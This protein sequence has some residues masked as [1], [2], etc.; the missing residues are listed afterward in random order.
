MVLT[1]VLI[2]TYTENPTH[3][4]E[5][6]VSPSGA[7]GIYRASFDTETGALSDYALAAEARISPSW[8]RAHPNLPVV[9]SVNETCDGEG[10]DCTPSFVSAYR[11]GPSGTLSLLSRVG[12]GGGSACNFALSPAGTHLAVANH[13]LL[14]GDDSGVS[15]CEILLTWPR[16]Q[17]RTGLKS[18]NFN[19]NSQYSGMILM[20]LLVGA[21]WHRNPISY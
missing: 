20:R 13:G 8:L 9:Y 5:F 18:D 3:A 11:V 14:M 10:E 17:W 1:T 2:G 7:E 4:P 15:Y 6:A 19:R 21:L 16:S 12:T